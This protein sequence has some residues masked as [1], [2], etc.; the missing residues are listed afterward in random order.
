MKFKYL[1]QILEDS[2]T[3]KIDKQLLYKE[4]EDINISEKIIENEI[5]K[6]IHEHFAE[7]FKFDYRKEN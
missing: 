2:E 4:I 6:R 3:L 5:Y 1:L 7:L